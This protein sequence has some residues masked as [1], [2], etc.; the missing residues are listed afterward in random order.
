MSLNSYS[1]HHFTSTVTLI[2]ATYSCKYSK[3]KK[4]RI[5]TITTYMLNISLIIFAF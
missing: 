5:V 2:S 3:Y 1:W 4:P